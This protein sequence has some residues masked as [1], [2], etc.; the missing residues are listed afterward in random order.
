[1]ACVEC[2]APILK[3]TR[4]RTNVVDV[5]VP[6]K[7]EAARAA[8]TRCPSTSRSSGSRRRSLRPRRPTP[9]SRGRRTSARAAIHRGAGS[10]RSRSRPCPSR[11]ACHNHAQDY[12][13]GR[14]TPCHVDLEDDEKPVKDYTHEANFP[15]DARQVAMPSID[16]LLPRSDDVPKCHTAHDAPHAAVDPVPGEGD[17][18]VHPPRRLDSRH[19]I[20]QQADPV[21]CSKCH[22]TGYCQSCHS[23]QGIAPGGATLR[24]PHPAGWISIHGQSARQNIVSCAA[25]HNQGANSICVACHTSGRVNPH[26]PGWKGTQAQIGGNPM[27][28]VCHTN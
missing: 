18:R 15:R 27:C 1:M 6:T 12:A 24:D 20:E 14:C 22:G 3:A 17:G 19:A 25:C 9:A 8:T 23:F 4:L 7:S 2:H 10:P 13:V 21:S 16:L 11:T 28:K 5:Q 26:P